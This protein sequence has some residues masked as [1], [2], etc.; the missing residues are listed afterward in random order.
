MRD[1]LR[2]EL[3][4]NVARFAFLFL[5][6]DFT[7][8]G[9]SLLRKV[10]GDWKGKLVKFWND[11][12]RLK[13]GYFADSLSVHV[14]HYVATTQA[15]QAI[16]QRALDIR[17]DLGDAW[18][19]QLTFSYG[20]VLPPEIRIDDRTDSAFLDV[21]E[22][23]YDQSIDVG[24]VTLKRAALPLSATAMASA[25]SQWFSIT[26]LRTI[27]FR[28]CGPKAMVKTAPMRCGHFFVE[29]NGTARH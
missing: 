29:D 22:Q 27:P 26:I 10:N 8:S 7:A 2:G 13:D 23:S 3:S 4:D 11:I 25:A 5:L 21:V 18:F 1:D 17:R 28:C 15:E 9:T 24:V 14:H 19:R 20:M 16:A 12:Q 6:D